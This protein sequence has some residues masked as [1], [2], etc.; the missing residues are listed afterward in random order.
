MEDFL[1]ICVSR[2][3]DYVRGNGLFQKRE[4]TNVQ[5]SAPLPHL[6]GHWN[7]RTQVKAKNS[8]LFL[9]VSVAAG[10]LTSLIKN[11]N[12]VQ[13]MFIYLFNEN[14]TFLPFS[15]LAQSAF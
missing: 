2:F 4:F 5:I 14:V 9:A 3:L 8:I 15:P 1:S 13:C 12:K 11:I 6:A 10:Q 7:P